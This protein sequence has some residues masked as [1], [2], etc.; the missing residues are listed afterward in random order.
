MHVYKNSGNCIL[1]CKAALN[2]SSVEVT[3]A[4]LSVE[5]EDVVRAIRGCDFTRRTR[6]KLAAISNK[7]ELPAIAAA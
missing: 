2:H 6:V 4:Y 3:Q 5:E 7:S 1:T